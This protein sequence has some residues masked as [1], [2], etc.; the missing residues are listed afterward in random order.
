MKKINLR[1][2]LFWPVLFLLSIDVY[3]GVTYKTFK[4]KSFKNEKKCLSV[5]FA[6][7]GDF[8]N[9]SGGNNGKRDFWKFTAEVAKAS[10]RTQRKTLRSLRYHGVLCGSPSFA[11]RSSALHSVLGITIA[12]LNQ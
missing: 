10:Q 8:W 9:L 4:I 11:L 3:Q 12:T 5:R 6:V 7:N 1:F 2:L